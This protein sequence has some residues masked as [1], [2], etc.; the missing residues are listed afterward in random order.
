M[1]V[2]VHLLGCL[3]GL[4][5]ADGTLRHPQKLTQPWLLLA[6]L[7]T[8]E[9]TAVDVPRLL[10]GQADG[11]L[12]PAVVVQAYHAACRRSRAA[13]SQSRAGLPEDARG[14]SADA[15]REDL[16][17][18][19][20]GLST[21]RMALNKI[22][23]EAGRE[24]MPSGRG[25]LALVSARTDVD[26]FFDLL[27]A[28]SYADA[29]AL[30][31]GAE[32][33]PTILEGTD[34]PWLKPVRLLYARAL[35]G[36]LAELALDA[37]AE[38]GDR[39]E[40][41]ERAV[42]ATAQRMELVD[43]LSQGRDADAQRHR[44]L[45][46][47]RDG[48]LRRLRELRRQ[49]RVS[50]VGRVTMLFSEIEASTELMRAVGDDYG[51]I[52]AIHHG[53]LREASTAESGTEI[54]T[55]DDAFFAAFEDPRHAIRAAVSAQ[56]ALRI[57][58]WLAG[59]EVRVRM[60][61]HTGSLR[62]REQNYWGIDVRY[63]A[64][65]CAA[66]SGGQV[67]VSAAT[68]ALVDV[69]LEDLGE[70]AV[71]GFPSARRI[72]H[73]PID[74]R[75]SDRFPPPDTLRSGRT[76]LPDQ[77]SSFVGRERE[78]ADLRRLAAGERLVTLA[79][80]GGVGKTRLALRVGADLLDGGGGGVWLVD[81]APLVDPTLV[82]LTA[83]AVL[84][85]TVRPG[86]DVLDAIGGAL[87][88]RE[89]LV[90]LDNCEHLVDAAA[91]LVSALLA[92]CPR[93][94][95]VATSREPLRVAGEHVY[96]VPSLSTPAQEI[97]DPA[98][99]SEYEAVQ[100]FAARAGEQRRDFGLYAGNAAT[101]GRI[102]RRLDG[103]PLAIELAAVR[104]R[105][106][107]LG[108]LDARLG[109]RFALLT[110]GARTDPPRH[111]T[112]LELIDWSY[113]LLSE[114]ERVVLAR[115]SEFAASG[116]DLEAAE[117]VC[118]TE[119]IEPRALVDLL[120]A[121]VD[122]SLV[123]AEDS[124]G[125]VRYRLLET[126]REYASARLAEAGDIA[127]SSARAAHRD[128]YGALA[129]AAAPQLIGAGQLAWLDRLSVEQDN[130]RLALGECLRDPDPEPGLRMAIALVRFWRARGHAA[131]GTQALHHQLERPGA[132]EAGLLRGEALAASSYLLGAV[133][134]EYDAARTQ[135]D[136]ALT[137]ARAHGDRSLEA[138]ALKLLALVEVRQGRFTEA[139][140]VSDKAIAIARSI[141]DRHQL[142]ELTNAHGAALVNLGRD[143]RAAFE[144]SLILSRQIG[145]RNGIATALNNLGA[146]EVTAGNLSAA[147]SRLE[148]ALSIYGE[149]GQRQ[150][151]A[152]AATNL[153]F[154][155]YREGDRDRAALL[156]SDALEAAQQQGDPGLLAM[157]LLGLALAATAPERAA[158][159]HGAAD[160][161]ID[162]IGYRLEHIE[163]PLR[164][165]DHARLAEVL[166]GD[167]FGIAYE[168]GRALTRSD[169]IAL[170]LDT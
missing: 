165:T 49:P 103:I 69:A 139:L 47:R 91:Q 7:A 124:S 120:D 57:H 63:V 106:M 109:D 56:R 123:Q 83:A 48:Y 85:V 4:I 21:V 10:G 147:R 170:A 24:L 122:K 118:S 8:P 95:I 72:F 137:I 11:Y 141:G 135:A 99:L 129:Q 126:V 88:D 27:G 79:G 151:A 58:A 145:D 117:A 34:A 98:C 53:L 133:L 17:L 162:E 161:V 13:L 150:N 115:M 121:L 134:C 94:S 65:L 74:G 22:L 40:L 143:A 43:Q 30:A 116:F 104:V 167:G 132:R 163:A 45:A 158:T 71:R 50:T 26:A 3:P 52:L 102:C 20:T 28:G 128:H 80:P 169:A 12:R 144:E 101:A 142:V 82:A 64:R 9:A 5:A 131:E 97:D 67:L 92:R 70:H 44:T 19:Q 127:A 33:L 68:A 138:Q 23:A 148:E 125:Q 96:R 42:N 32:A 66:A 2:R 119:E 62:V 159:L 76:N 164:E 105:S 136:E 37:D 35:D 89:L 110:G 100:L 18:S 86:E 155:C 31:G 168:T 29:I 51:E 146:L 113:R 54:E 107:S 166:G 39:V 152:N 112:L 73:L 25:P 1:Q 6:R 75:G 14:A 90:V 81:L 61:V 160:A 59:A 38:A 153:G 41:V 114:P 16:M 154:T 60:G 36:A 46:A 111:H 156:F 87:A 77:L 78:L 157:T 108:D 84:S 149:L 140:A 55:H 15:V 130:L 93:V